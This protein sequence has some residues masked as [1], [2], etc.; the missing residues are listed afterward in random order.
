MHHNRLGLSS[1]TSPSSHN[2]ASTVQYGTLIRLLNA[3]LALSASR[4]NERPIRFRTAET[5]GNA[6]PQTAGDHG[7][8]PRSRRAAPAGRH[9][10]RTPD[11]NGLPRYR[12]CVLGQSQGG[13]DLPGLLALVITLAV[14][15]SPLLLC[16]PP[17]QSDAEPDEGGGDG[18][19]PPRAPTQPPGG[20]IPL[21]DAQPA[22]VRLRTHERLAA[23][24]PSR[25]R[26]PARPARTPTSTPPSPS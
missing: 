16:R 17:G 9:S 10:A 19:Q 14:V 26:R 7:R 6:H 12:C 13:L 22:R 23:R 18:P 20:G 1:C 15:F 5:V 2:A 3:A 8:K 24:R 4:A 25:D 11:P 21:D